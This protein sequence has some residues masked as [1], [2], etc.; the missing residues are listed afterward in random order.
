MSTD[1]SVEKFW[2]AFKVDMLMNKKQRNSKTIPKRCQD[3]GCQ[4]SVKGTIGARKD[5]P[6]DR[7]KDRQR[8]FLN[9]PSGFNASGSRQIPAFAGNVGV[10]IDCRM[11]RFSVLHYS[12]QDSAL[13]NKSIDP[14]KECRKQ[15]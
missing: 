9:V 3:C 2:V 10:S 15:S 8:R 6:K 11:G 14:H 13:R 1:A 12:R 7:P 4:R 5:C